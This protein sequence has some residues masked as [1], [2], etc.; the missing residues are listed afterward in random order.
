MISITRHRNYD[1][2]TLR[3]RWRGYDSNWN[4]GYI[5]GINFNDAMRGRF[6]FSGL[7][8]MTSSA[9]RNRSTDIG[10]DAA[11][12]GYGNIG[13]SSNFTTYASEYAPGFKGS[14]AYTN[15]SYMLRA[16]SSIPQVSTP[17]DGRSLPASSAD[18]PRK[19]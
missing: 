15:S 1:F 4:T 8:G 12:F 5:N 18:M 6:N 2:S 13:G 7:G 9:F 17:R 10:L 16:I 11:P 19:A 14:L 3:F